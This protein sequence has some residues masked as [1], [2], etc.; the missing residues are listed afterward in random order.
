MSDQNKQTPSS[1]SSPS[2]SFITLGVDD[3]ERS[4]AFY[5]DGLGFKTKGIVGKEIE[6]GAVAFFH[7]Q[8][9]LRLALW[10]RQSIAFEHQLSLGPRDPAG[11]MLA[12]NVT[13]ASEVDSLIAC[14]RA[15]GAP[16]LREPKP[17]PW[18]GYGGVFADPDEHLWE[19]VWNPGL[20]EL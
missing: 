4:V 19:I 16:I 3:L 15:A 2:V 6:N 1:F 17:F 12:H 8:P 7:L 11:M 18:G 10:P 5:R 20:S 14:A 9:G 13:T